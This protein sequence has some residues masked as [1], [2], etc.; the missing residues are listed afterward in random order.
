MDGKGFKSPQR[1]FEDSWVMSR[2]YATN[3]TRA[4]LEKNPD[5]TVIE[6]LALFEHEKNEAERVFQRHVNSNGSV[7]K[8]GSRYDY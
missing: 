3:T 8:I 7:V 2:T 1:T 5:L 6:L 4:A